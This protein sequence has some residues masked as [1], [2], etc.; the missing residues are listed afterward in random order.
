LF[1]ALRG[2]SPTGKLSPAVVPH[3]DA[4]ADD[5]G[6]GAAGAT[7]AVASGLT[8]RIFLE[9][10][11]HEAIVQESYKDSVG[12]WTWAIG[13]T[14]ASGHDVD[15]Y[16]DNPQPLE[17]CIEVSA[18]LMREKYL[19]AVLKAFEGRALTEAQLG[20]A[21]SFHYNTGAIG[22]A[23]WVTAWKAGSVTT[24]RTAFM[25]YRKPTEIILRREKERDLFFDGKWSSDGK[26]TVYQVRKPS[27][28]PDWGSAKRV[29]IRALVEKVLAA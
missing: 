4:I 12:V 22:K 13:V 28:S 15:R 27:Y 24:A 6:M 17:K 5:W 29:D 8:A 7:P 26:T 25:N 23:D 20:A 9:L 10:A 11:D 3:I 19:P 14:D 18:W 16:R 21:L 2:L 1:D